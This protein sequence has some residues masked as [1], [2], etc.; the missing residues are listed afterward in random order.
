M[1]RLLFELIVLLAVVS[2]AAVIVYRLAST[3]APHQ[4]VDKS[5]TWKPESRCDDGLTTVIAAVLVSRGG[6][7]RERRQLATLNNA[8]PDYD[9]ALDQALERASSTAFIL[10]SRREL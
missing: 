4:L 8:A 3:R 1:G 10:N 7:I 2:V 5:F 9:V 6:E